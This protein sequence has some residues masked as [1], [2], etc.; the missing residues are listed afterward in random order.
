MKRVVFAAPFLMD[1]TTRFVRSVAETQGVRLGLVT[2]EPI[3]KVPEAIRS[4]LAGHWRAGDLLDPEGLERAVRG[5]AEQVGGV[6]LLLG[7]LEQLQ[8]PLAEVR[9]RLAIPG[10]RSEAAQ[11]FR[12]KARMKSVLRA[13]GLPCARHRLAATAEEAR[14]FASEIGYPLVMKPP[15]GAGGKA[16]FRIERAA[17]LDVALRAYA[18]AAGREALLEE[19]IVGQEHSLDTVSIRGKAVWHSLTVYEPTPLH[20][21]ETPWIQWCVLLPREVDHPRY[22]DIR[23]TGSRAL[24][25]LG[26]GTGVSHMEWFRRRDGSV[27]ISEVGA[28]PP[29]AQFCT[30]ISLA[31]DVDFYR[32]WAHL[33]VHEE[34]EP[35]RRAYAAGGAYLRGQGSGRVKAIRG[36]EEVQKE[37]G[38]VI[39]EVRLPQPGQPS[40][41]SYEG[42]GYVLLR[43]PDTDVVARGLQRI[44]SLVRVDLG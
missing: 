15:A 17:D 11:S 28:R 37:L 16:T 23:R 26:M 35:P 44:V 42:E 9:E 14:R 8:V 30:L 32:L 2:Q 29:G 4:R 31:H 25:A 33:V 19:F 12:D 40:T 7:T 1:T 13:N 36:L 6:D 27:A 41:G 39:A 43:H 10:M 21:L 3:E 38:S 22:D 24:E 20:V 5:V 34:F 18:P